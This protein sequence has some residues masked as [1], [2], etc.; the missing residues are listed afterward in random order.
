MATGPAYLWA[1]DATAGNPAVQAA[2]TCRTAHAAKALA[3]IYS[4]RYGA[5]SS[6]DEY[7][8]SSRRSEIRMGACLQS[9]SVGAG[10][11]F[12]GGSAPG[13]LHQHLSGALVLPRNF[14]PADGYK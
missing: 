4:L 2:G 14:F 1:A 13:I 8:R 10:R 12:A 9:R 5:Y 3:G 7:R 6:K 11:R